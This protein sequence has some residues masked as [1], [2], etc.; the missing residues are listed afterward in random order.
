MN[1]F[2][3]KNLTPFKWFVLENFPFIEADFDALTEWQLFCKIGKEI[4]KII[5]STN[6]LGTQVESLTDYVKNYFDN[7]DV[8][9]E[10]NNKLNE[11]VEDGT[12]QEIITSY[13]N[14]KGILAFNTKA[15]MKN[16]TNIIDGSFVKTFG[17][18]EFNDGYGEFYKI[19]EI[20]NTD[21]VDDINIIAIM[22]NPDLVAELIKN[23]TIEDIETKLAKIE[24]DWLDPLNYGAVGDGITDDYAV[25]Q[26][27]INQGNVR[28]SKGS[29]YV[30]QPI[31]IPSNRVFDGG[32]CII[33]PNTNQYAI[34]LNG[35]SL[36][37][38]IVEVV[39]KNIQIRMPNGG[40]GIKIKDSYFIYI[41]NI[42]IIEMVGNNLIGIDIENGF[43]HIITNSRIYGGTGYEGQI[44]L[45][46]VATKEQDG[47]TNMTNCKYDSLLIQNI[48]Y[49]VKTNYQTTANMIEFNNMG[50]SNCNYCFYLD[51]YCLPMK[52][53]N[54][55]MEGGNRSNK[56]GFYIGSNILLSID[57]LNAY[58]IDYVI[59]NY[60]SLGGV[61]LKLYGDIVITGT[62][63]TP[64]K[65]FIET[66]KTSSIFLYGKLY[67]QSNAYN[68]ILADVFQDYSTFICC[69]DY[70]FGGDNT[71]SNIALSPI[72]KVIRKTTTD[73]VN[74]RGIKGC[75]IMVYCDTP[76]TIASSSSSDTS[77]L[78]TAITMIPYKLYKIKLLDTSKFT[79]IE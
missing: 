51:G 65:Y 17:N 11:M 36:N 63:T 74:V 20:K 50:F 79:V 58:N 24:N 72:I 26:A 61:G 49:G 6:T 12:L 54:T 14:V 59:A 46:I 43:N 5:N 41:D 1:K 16:A 37:N 64:K 66:S 77:L 57:T 34:L 9:E 7:L 69:T 33:K 3:F 76:H 8:Q 13:L 28:L 71:N 19:R 67:L 2:E 68:D 73:I 55:R 42:N 27:C 15:D 78:T 75:E 32:N 38:A 52:I 44:G 21:V 23:Q 62:V 30:S 25:L 40:N 53:S 60:S 18:L 22:T 45:N 35:Q 29:Y 10:I 70:Q 48:D 56:R 39:L 4:N 31:E 47:I